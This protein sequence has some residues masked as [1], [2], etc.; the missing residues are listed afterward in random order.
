MQVLVMMTT[1]WVTCLISNNVC[2]DRVRTNDVK[3]IGIVVDSLQL[4]VECV[5]DKE[6]KNCTIARKSSI[7]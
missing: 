4:I 3:L 2:S 5:E 6:L 1:L 7:L